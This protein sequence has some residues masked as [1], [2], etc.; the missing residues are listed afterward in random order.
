[1]SVLLLDDDGIQKSLSAIKD[2][3]GITGFYNTKKNPFM[4]LGEEITLSG[5]VLSFMRGSKEHS[6]SLPFTGVHYL[7]NG[8][9]AILACE[10]AGIAAEKSIRTLSGYKG[11]SRRLEF[12]GMSRNA[13]IYDDYA[14]HPTEISAVISSIDL[15]KPDST[16]SRTIVLFQ[17]HRYTRTRDLHREFA[18]VLGKADF[19]FLLPV[20]SAGEEPI[21]GISSNSIFRNFPNK[22]KISLLSGNIDKDINEIAHYIRENDFFVSIGA[23]SVRSWAEALVNLPAFL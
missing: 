12:I 11:V 21:P 15:M 19:V 18:D 10:K 1:V 2:L 16:R 5:N 17:P 6:L 7:R 20:Y 23:G 13:Q 9:L 8:F 4:E 3:T 14:H 22:N